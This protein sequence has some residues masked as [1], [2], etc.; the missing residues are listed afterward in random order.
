MT[1]P[2][3]TRDEKMSCVRLAA[4]IERLH[5]EAQSPLNDEAASVAAAGELGR[6]VLR[7]IDLIVTGL[8]NA[9]R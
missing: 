3:L 5:A 9:G 7:H 2:R 6:T 4:V 1:A 8:K